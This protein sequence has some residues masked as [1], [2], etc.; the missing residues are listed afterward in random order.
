MFTER[1]FLQCVESYPQF[2][3]KMFVALTLI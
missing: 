1:I 3:Y 2:S